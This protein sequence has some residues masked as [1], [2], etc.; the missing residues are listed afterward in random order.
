MRLYHL[1]SIHQKTHRKSYL[2][3]YAMPHDT[4]CAMLKRFTAH[5]LRIIMLE[6][7]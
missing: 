3:R 1:I 4:A 6:E 2:T 7:I 5:A